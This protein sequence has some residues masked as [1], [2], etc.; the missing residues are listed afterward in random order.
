MQ[1]IIAIK[2]P[3]IAI[4]ASVNYLLRLSLNTIVGAA[5]MSKTNIKAKRKT[6]LTVLLI[7]LLLGIM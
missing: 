4:I 1:Q 7:I 5:N 6:V 2:T 3:T